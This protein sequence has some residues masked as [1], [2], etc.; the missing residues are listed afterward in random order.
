M[1]MSCSYRLYIK[2]YFTLLSDFF[3]RTLKYYIIIT[4][5]GVKYKCCSYSNYIFNPLT[6]NDL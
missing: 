5:D 6:P 1:Q 2:Q 4:K 3:S